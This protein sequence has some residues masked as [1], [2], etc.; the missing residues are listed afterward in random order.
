[1]ARSRSYGTLL[2]SLAVV[3]SPARARSKEVPASLRAAFDRLS[4][5]GAITAASLAAYGFEAGKAAELVADADTNARLRGGASDV[6]SVTWPQYVDAVRF[7]HDEEIA[8]LSLT[9][10]SSFRAS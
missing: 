9:S 8:A 10:I 2:H 5:G 6:G 1:M 4:S 3:D 7:V